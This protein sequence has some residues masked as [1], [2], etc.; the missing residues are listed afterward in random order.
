MEKNQEKEA[1]RLKSLAYQW[2]KW[3]HKVDHDDYDEAVQEALLVGKC[4]VAKSD[5]CYSKN[6]RSALP[7]TSN[8]VSRPDSSAG[9]RNRR[10]CVKTN[11]MEVDGQ[12][13][14]P[15]WLQRMSFELLGAL[16]PSRSLG[17]LA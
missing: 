5:I 13:P 2:W 14:R 15:D 3:I 11:T 10:G 12:A 1:V 7:A 8:S 16:R 6:V 17:S 9:K 4:I